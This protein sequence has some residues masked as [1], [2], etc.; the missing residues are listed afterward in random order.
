MQYFLIFLIELSVLF[1]LSKSLTKTLSQ[2]LLFITKSRKFTVTIIALLFFPGVVIHELAHLLT[3]GILFVPVG[4]IELTPQVR[5]NGE[6]R[7]GSVAVAKTDPIRGMIIGIA[8]ILFGLTVIVGVP[9][10]LSGNITFVFA[11]LTIYLL[12]VVGNTMFSSRKDLEGMVELFVILLILALAFYIIDFRWPL[13][14]F[15][16]FLNR[17]SSV[18]FF[19]QINTFLLWTIAIDAIAVT[20]IKLVGS[21]ICKYRSRN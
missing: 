12:F 16:S 20:G 11:A 14:A 1:F 5:E 10:F 13:D 3:A 21:V 8:P 15:P 6:V 7:L 2:A 18:L 4:D 9:Y 19:K 17:E